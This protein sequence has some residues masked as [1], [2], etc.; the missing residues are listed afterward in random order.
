MATT[1]VR[2]ATWNNIGTDISEMKDV[3][4]ILK[5]TNLDYDVITLPAG[6]IREKG[7]ED[8]QFYATDHRFTVKADT[9]E[10]ISV[11]SN[12]YVP[13]Q[14]RDAFAF[15]DYVAGEDESFKF[16]KAGETKSH[17][18]YIIGKTSPIN[19]LGDEITPYIIFSNSHDGRSSVR[20]TITPLRIV[21]NNQFRIAFRESPNTVYVRHDSNA[22]VKLDDAQKVLS[23]LNSYMHTFTSEAE[24]LATSRL[25]KDNAIKIFNSLFDKQNMTLRQQ[26]HTENM[27]NQFISAYEADDNQNF[28]NTAW[29]AINAASDFIT[30]KEGRK[31]TD[32]NKFMSVTFTSPFLQQFLMSVISVSV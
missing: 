13:V 17:F 16:V 31:T 5:A 9:H 19:V 22:M 27:R 11:V 25:S 15:V 32:D 28:Q 1:N 10:P 30:H 8:P 7:V 21:C 26:N 29:G 6:F 18:V 3:S 2:T 24:N 12:K 23:S 4:Q 20:A 14:N